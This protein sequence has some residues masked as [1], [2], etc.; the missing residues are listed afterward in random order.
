MPDTDQKLRHDI[1]VIGGGPVGAAF[2]L[3]L[4]GSGRNVLLM[5]GEGE[6]ARAADPRSIALSFGSRLLLERLG[7]WADV[8]GTTAIHTIHVSQQGGFGRTVLN[9]QD[10]GVPALGYVASYAALQGALRRKLQ[11]CADITVQA[12]RARGLEVAGDTMCVSFEGPDSQPAAAANLAVIADGGAL[13]QEIARTQVR[14]YG[15][16]AIVANVSTAQPHRHVAYER[17]TPAGPLALL[18]RERGYALV[19]TASH[20]AANRLRE[21]PPPAFVAAL[22]A[23]FGYRAGRFT[24]VEARSAYPLSLRIARQISERRTVML[25]NAAQSLHP[26][27]GQGLNL[28][29]R[30]AWDLAQRLRTAQSDAGDPAVLAAFQRSRRSDRSSTIFL[31]DFLVRIFSNDDLALRWLRGCG[32]TILDCLPPA[33]RAFMQQMTFGRPY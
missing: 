33:K 25:G 16:S 15:Q 23:A 20:E 7:V 10:A 27:A 2:A 32:L 8:S 6:A 26:V 29:L 18:P 11:G 30:D 28:A 1:I 17:F 9:A 3:A 12:V 22:Q 13:A 21:L 31:T 19:W 24:G 14:E 5:Q 4:Q